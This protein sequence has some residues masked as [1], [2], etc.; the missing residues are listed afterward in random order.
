MKSTAR[1][2]GPMLRGTMLT[3]ALSA[4]G[5]QPPPDGKAPGEGKAPAEAAKAETKLRPVEALQINPT[6]F[7]EA[8]EVSG[9]LTAPDDVVVAARG[10]G[11]VQTLVERGTRV[12][13]DEILARVDPALPNAGAAQARASIRLA[14]A[15]LSLARDTMARQ[16][17]LFEKGI[18]SALEYRHLQGQVDQARAQLAQARAAAQSA[19]TQVQFTTVKA[20]FAGIV[21][22]R[23]TE[24]GAQLAPGQ[25]VVRLVNTDRLRVKAG[26]PERYARDVKPGQSATLDFSTYGL[27]PRTGTISFVGQ[28]IEP[29]S[30]TFPV[31]ID[32]DNTDGALKPEMSVRLK[33]TRPPRANALVVPQTAV[34]R[35]VDSE[36]VFVIEKSGGTGEAPAAWTARRVVV[37]LGPSS[38]GKVLVLDGLTPGARVVTRGQAN[39]TTGDGVRLESPKPVIT[40]PTVPVQIS[41]TGLNAEAIE[42]QLAKP[43]EAHLKVLPGVERLNSASR[44][45]EL[46]VLVHFSGAVDVDEAKRRIEART[47]H[48]KLPKGAALTVGSAR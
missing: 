23:L 24:R 36:S 34:L 10:A 15:G 5:C 45:G 37:K 6:R 17:P 31:E 47:A 29:S 21:E 16:K 44:D 25:P 46:T 42:E 19:Q 41:A 22:R 7:A 2:A 32:L 18:I 4:I 48:F 3:L 43:L 1:Q 20:P 8:F 40:T 39:L 14:Q 35:D 28:A 13:K 33:L 30:R 27:K 9:S 26:V 11:S 38:A 12:E